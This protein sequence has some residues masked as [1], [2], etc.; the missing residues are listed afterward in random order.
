M[1][2][3]EATAFGPSVRS[4]TRPSCKVTEHLTE[5]E[6]LHELPCMA[7]GTGMHCIAVSDCYPR[8]I[9]TCPAGD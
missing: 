8:Y 2:L 6:C 9:Q 7:A 1:R 3:L 5:L 4:S